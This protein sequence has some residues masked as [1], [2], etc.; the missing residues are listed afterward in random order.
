MLELVRLK[1][2]FALNGANLKVPNSVVKDCGLRAVTMK[3]KKYTNNRDT[4]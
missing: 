1:V 4:E 2:P 3:E